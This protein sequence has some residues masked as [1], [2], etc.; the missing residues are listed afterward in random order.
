MDKEVSFRDD[1]N[2]LSMVMVAQLCECIEVTVY[3]K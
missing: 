3:F 1:E 2:T